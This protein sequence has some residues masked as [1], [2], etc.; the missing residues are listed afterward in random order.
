MLVNIKFIKQ[1]ATFAYALYPSLK[2]FL[3]NMNT[4]RGENIWVGGLTWVF[5]HTHGYPLKSKTPKYHKKNHGL[6]LMMLSLK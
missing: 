2:I 4:P 5:I 1:T 3:K 6:Q